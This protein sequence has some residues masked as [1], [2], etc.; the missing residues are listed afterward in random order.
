MIKVNSIFFVVVLAVFV[1]VEAVKYIL[2]KKGVGQYKKLIPV[3]LPI[4]IVATYGIITRNVFDMLVNGFAI[5]VCSCYFY[6]FIAGIFDFFKKKI[7]K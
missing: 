3:I 1:I 2:D 4:I 6:D 7:Y 5:T